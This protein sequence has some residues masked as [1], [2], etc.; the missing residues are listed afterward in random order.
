MFALL[1]VIC[2]SVTCVNTASARTCLAEVRSMAET[3]GLSITPPEVGPPAEPDGVEPGDL[4]RSGGVIEP[5]PISDPAVIE[6]PRDAGRAMPTLPSIPEDSPAPLEAGPRHLSPSDRATLESILV[7][8]RAN[9]ESGDER[10]CF[11]RLK[12]AKG[13]IQDQ[14]S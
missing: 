11:E 14:G 2:A 5:P 13:V 4:A 10:D 8:A 3:Y 6:P 7:A 1:V 9:A 12:T